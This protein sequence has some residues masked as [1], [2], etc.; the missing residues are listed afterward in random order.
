[1][2]TSW[3]YA[4]DVQGVPGGLGWRD[5]L[6][7]APP[8]LKLGLAF[9][10]AALMTMGAT[11]L[12]RVLVLH[13]LGIAATGIYQAAAN[14][15]SVYVAV[16]LRAMFTDFY[17]RLA[18]AADDRREFTA[19]V[20]HQIEVGALLALPGILATITLAPFV[21]TMFYS[22][23]FLPSVGILRWQIMGVFL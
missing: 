7:E 11:Y 5:V 21:I 6:A 9:M 13:H 17:P 12:V 19:L 3:W 15:S 16:I 22:S 18:A 8:L 4:R 2:A 10:V 20:N 23:E 1:L 14:L